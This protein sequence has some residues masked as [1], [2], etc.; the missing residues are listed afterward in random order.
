M[1][2]AVLCMVLGLQGL[3]GSFFIGILRLRRL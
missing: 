3:L 1:I 2:P